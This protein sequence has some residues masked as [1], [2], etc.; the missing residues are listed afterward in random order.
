MKVEF[1]PDSLPLFIELSDEA[2]TGP[3]QHLRWSCLRYQL[4]FY[5]H[6]MSQGV[7][8]VMGF[9]NL[10][11]HFVNI[12]IIINI[13]FITYIITRIFEQKLMLL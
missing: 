2:H 6:C 12:V 8:V 10:S 5:G 3:K 1:E 7:L 4:M 11:L 13:I 9:L